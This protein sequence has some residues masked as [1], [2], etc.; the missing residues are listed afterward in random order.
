MK[1]WG[2]GHGHSGQRA[3]EGVQAEDGKNIFGVLVSYEDLCLF[4]LLGQE[5]APCQR[6][7]PSD[8]SAWEGTLEWRGRYGPGESNG[9]LWE[10]S[11]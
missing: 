10:P 9:S 2:V 1:E 8:T 7:L 5:G 6:L 11:H 3:R 4:Q